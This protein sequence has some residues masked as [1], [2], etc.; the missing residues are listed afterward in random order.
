MLED[1]G[2][3][4]SAI[5][6]QDS[7][8]GVLD[9]PSGSAAGRIPRF[10]RCHFGLIEGFSGQG[11]LPQEAFTEA[12]VDVF[13]NVAETTNA[14]LSLSL[15]LG[16]RVL[17][18]VLKKLY[19]QRG[20]GRRESALYRGLDTRARQLVDGVLRLL[21]REG[22]AIRCRQA[23]EAIWLPSKSSDARRRVLSLLAAPTTSADPLIA[24]SRDLD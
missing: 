1:T 4:L 2:R 15:P 16:T 14:I 6:L 5:Q 17:L 10:F 13:G 24:Q 18:T 11:D 23:D 19:A 7:I 20:S 3:A 9:V 8:I 12:T 21:R 22:F